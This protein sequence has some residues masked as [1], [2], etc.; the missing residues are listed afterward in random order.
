[1]L[2]R[3]A[4][5]REASGGILEALVLFDTDSADRSETYRA[6]LLS[7]PALLF[8]TLAVKISVIA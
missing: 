3:N 2:R 4:G 5:R 8:V 7:L 1:L 6:L